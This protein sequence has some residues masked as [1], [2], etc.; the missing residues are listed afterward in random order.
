MIGITI[1]ALLALSSLGQPSTGSTESQS[2]RPQGGVRAMTK[3][4]PVEQKGHDE[5]NSAQSQP[6][7]SETPP[8]ASRPAKPEGPSADEMGRW[9]VNLAR[10]Q[11]H[12]LGH[13]DPRS[14]SLHVVALL[15]GARLTAPESPDAYYWLFDLYYRLGRE[16]T[17]REALADYVRLAPS[18]EA[19]RIRLLEFELNRRQTAEERAGYLKSELE[20][21]DLPRVY[22]SELHRSLAEFHFE[23]RE[24]KEAAREAE[25]ALRLN[26]LNVL[27]RRLAYQ[28]FSETEAALQRVET[29]L[30]LISIN[31]SQASVVWDLGEFLDQ[32]SLH[33]Q[34]QEF[35][36]RAIEIHQR[37][38]TRPVP[39]DFWY[40]LAVSY[41]RSGDWTETR[42]A[43]GSA[44]KINENLHLA[45][46]LRSTAAEKLDEHE[47]AK[48]DLD[49]V[50][51]AYRGRLDDV[52]EKHLHDEAAEIG[53][54]YCYHQPNKEQALKV[55]ELAMEDADPSSLARLAYGYALRLNGRS[56]EAVKTLKPLAGE[57]QLAAVELARILIARGDKSEAIGVL[58]KAADLQYTGFAH[59]MIRDLL[60]K[61]GET[62]PE[63]PLNTKV[64]TALERFHREV[65]DYAKRPGD[66][67]EVSLKFAEDPLPPLGPVL[68]VFRAENK[69]PFT[70]SFG[71]GYMARA[72][73]AL[74]ANLNG[75][76]PAE[77]KNYLQV[78]MD[79]RPVLVSGDAVEKTVAVDV[80]PVQEYLHQTVTRP[81]EIELTALFDPVYTE[82]RLAAGPGTI[83]AR[84]IKAVRSSLAVGPANMAALLERAGSPHAGDRVEAAEAISALL[85]EARSSSE[86]KAADLPIEALS[87]A[88]AGLLADHDWRV[89]S[90]ALVGAG[91]SPLDGRTT[92]AAAQAVRDQE[93]PVVKMLAVRLFAQQHG[94][95]FKPVLI[96]L[97]K[98]DPNR[99]VRI[100][101]R[102]FLP[103]S[104]GAQANKAGARSEETLP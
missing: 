94:E 52:R 54:F 63:A 64:I 98:S 2:D 35:Y 80:G 86:A 3:A 13:T 78:L 68:A 16:D 20:K 55:A 58:H 37:A 83:T 43:A 67:L 6:P 88:L 95:K 84:S 1:G 77:H 26:P 81:V 91:W 10:H 100:M 31:P 51:N 101:S 65:F 34:A 5:N 56:D 66:F 33:H 4:R 17:A 47:A 44:L 18:D 27:A 53:W 25:E 75:A 14:A 74:S 61:Q 59:D 19:A 38:E 89:R 69:G 42:N 9:L 39:A 92:N 15:E 71:E 29:A 11:G 93:S 23:Q 96:Q 30:Q 49:F 48:E 24:T 73:V 60:A 50:A 7:D 62:A 45:R 104:L 103:D 32:L 102:S 87:T 8:A 40:R 90:R 28:M 79:S 72:L 85:A 22:A 97:A 41:S 70:I 57:D 99:C 21:P 46:L 82:G 12:L 76:T 36:T